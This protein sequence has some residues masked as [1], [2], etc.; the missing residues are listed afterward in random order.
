[1]KSNKIL[2]GVVLV[3]LGALF[4][5]HN[6][7]V[8]NFHWGNIF[9]LWPVFLIMGGVNLVLA[10]RHEAW[11]TALKVFV[12]VGCFCL[13]VFVPNKHHYFWNH[14]NGN[15]N[16]SDHD[17]DHNDD[18]DDD[19]D[20]DTTSS[21]GV[22]KV[23]GASTYNEPYNAA[24]KRARLNLNGAASEYT[25][26][27]TTGELFNAVTKEFYTK[28]DYIHSLDSGVFTAT[29]KMRDQKGKG[30]HWDSDKTNSAVIKLNTAPEW[31][32]N[33][34]TG[35]SALEFDLEKFK[36]RNLIIDG[37]AASFEVKMGQPLATTNIEVSTGISGVT[38]QIPKD[39]A[40]SIVTSSGLSSNDFEGFDDK[41]N[42]HYETP[43][44]AAAKNKM[45][46][47][48]KGGLSGFEVKRY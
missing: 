41:G 37:G 32:I 12:V 27:D 5:L 17:Y 1:M 43:G 39:A 11:A 47:K 23:E 25:I 38:I 8:I 14:H 40:C 35:A 15:W 44:F 26:K 48:L 34:R 2:P 21:K 9:T 18:N 33:V 36:I 31:D 24:V 16:F 45:Y 7:N 3:L 13:L 29:L 6:Y 28:Y 4:L 46:I 22:I 30:F 20:S 42:S 19:D 10:N